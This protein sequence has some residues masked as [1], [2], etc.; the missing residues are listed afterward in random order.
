MAIESS[1]R[2]VVKKS[3]WKIRKKSAFQNSVSPATM[4]LPL[5]QARRLAKVL[6]G[7]AF[8]SV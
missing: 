5:D 2:R 8:G 4:T 7:S 3:R 1:I 6:T